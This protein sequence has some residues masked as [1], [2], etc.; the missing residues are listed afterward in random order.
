MWPQEVECLP[1]DREGLSSNSCNLSPP[2]Q[3][4]KVSLVTAFLHPHLGGLVWEQHLLPT[5]SMVSLLQAFSLPSWAAMVWFPFWLPDLLL[6]ASHANSPVCQVVAT[7]L[8]C[9]RQYQRGLKSSCET[10]V[11]NNIA[12]FSLWEIYFFLSEIKI[13]LKRQPQ[14]LRNKWN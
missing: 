2:C 3:E 13:K 5:G 10:K 12:T 7:V 4:K 14:F 8:V 1:S 9:T 11:L 6:R